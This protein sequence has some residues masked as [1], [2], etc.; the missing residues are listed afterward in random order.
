MVTFGY[1]PLASKGVFLVED[2]GQN[3]GGRRVCR[4]GE[5]GGAMVWSA[6]VLVKLLL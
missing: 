1:D 6:R 4:M 2:A 5:G 3:E